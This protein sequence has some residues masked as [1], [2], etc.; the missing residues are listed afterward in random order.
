MQIFGKGIIS[1]RMVV[2]TERVKFVLK[3]F[4][5]NKRVVYQAQAPSSVL[6]EP[7]IC[8]DAIELMDSNISNEK[9]GSLKHKSP[10]SSKNSRP[11]FRR[12]ISEKSNSSVSED[13]KT[14]RSNKS[15][16]SIKL[17]ISTYYTVEA[18]VLDQSWAL[19][20]KEWDVIEERR[21]KNNIEEELV[22]SE[23]NKYA[24]P[25]LS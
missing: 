21:L 2:S 16:S 19:T 7:Y 15:G 23:N 6:V 8:L 22:P 17:G 18:F 4:D 11:S 3:I 24:S 25:T 20:M 9:K 12:R 14:S 1:L 13:I 10:R 5:E